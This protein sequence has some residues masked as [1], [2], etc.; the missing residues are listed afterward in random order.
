MISEKTNSKKL[1]AEALKFA[2]KAHAGQER[3]TGGPYI[4]HP[5]AVANILE[6]YGA[7]DE[8]IAAGYLHDVVEDTPIT[9]E[10]IRKKFGEEIAFLVDGVTK[11]ENGYE[12]FRK[13]KKYSSKDKRVFFVKLADRIHNLETPIDSEE[14]KNKYHNT[15]KEFYIPLAREYGFDNLA[16]RLEKLLIR[17]KNAE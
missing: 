9:L 10:E 2:E 14:W 11:E 1:A 16:G 6:G 8:T 13:I 3:K 17:L 5:V 4:A 15:T 7:D 12:T